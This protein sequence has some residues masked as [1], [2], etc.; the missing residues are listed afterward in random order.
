MDRAGLDTLDPVATRFTRA[1]AWGNRRRWLAIGLPWCALCAGLLFTVLLTVYVSIRMTEVD[2]A[3]FLHEVE[4]IEAR[5]ERRM[6]AHESLL[7]GAAGLLRA[8]DHVSREDWKRYTDQLELQRNYPGLQGLGLSLRIPSS[9]RRAHEST[10]REE[11]PPYAIRP[12]TARDEYHS[13]VYLEPMDA[14]NLRAIGYDMYSEPTRAEAMARA[15]DNGVAALSGQVVLVQEDGR[16]VQPGFLLYYPVYRRD[17]VPDSAGSRREALIG[18]TYSP[19]RAHDLFGNTLQAYSRELGIELFDGDTP[20]PVR[21]LF[22]AGP[23]P[24]GEAAFTDQRVLRLA[25]HQWTLLTRAP[26]GFASARPLLWLLPLGGALL[27]GLL[28]HLLRLLTR[29]QEARLQAQISSHERARS[30][31]RLSA[32]LDHAPDGIVTTDE[33]GRLLT[34]NQSAVNMFGRD[35]SRLIGLPLS[36]LIPDLDAECFL[37]W[38]SEGAGAA[39]WQFRAEMSAVR[40]ARQHFPVIVLASRF[41][42]DGRMNY[43]LLLHDMSEQQAAQMRMRL[44][45]RALESSGEGVVIRDVRDPAYPVVYVNPALERMMKLRGEDLIGRPFTFSR[46]ADERH[47]VYDDL[48]RAIAQDRT[49]STTVEVSLPSGEVLWLALSSSPVRDVTGRVTHYIDIIGDVSER[50]RFERTLIRRTHRLNAVFSLSP[51]GFVTIDAGGVISN[52]NPAFLQ[53]TGL[54]APALQG[55]TLDGLDRAMSALADPSRRWPPVAQDA[56]RDSADHLWMRI[57]EPRVLERRVR[58][59]REG[60]SETVLYFRDVTQQIELDRVKSEFLGTAAHELRSPLASIS[61]FAELLLNREYDETARKRMY[62][63]IHRQSRLLVNLVNDLLDLGRIEARAGKDFRYEEV[64][65][66][67]LVSAALES[68]GAIDDT[69]PVAL[70][71]PDSEPCV[72]ADRDKMVRVLINVL[73][74][75]FKYSP[76]GSEVCIAVGEGTRAG[77]AMAGISVRDHGIGM[78]E[79]QKARMCERFYRADPTGPVPGTGLGMALVKEIV[80]LHDGDIDVDSAPGEGTTVTLWLPSR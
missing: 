9:D 54:S 22:R 69:H 30:E 68:L 76:P 29:S 60:R 10:V 67:W 24:E 32:V 39:R 56:A 27:S 15:R 80:A 12:D 35:P 62:G 23:A 7:R 71:L 36:R 1:H 66:K 45:D 37:R 21:R 64:P 72:R 74:N 4:R 48:R 5:I 55:L 58:M 8:S 40:N 28:F 49:L 17:S 33:S 31:K 50:V 53:M 65:L 26:S 63:I 78:T 73:T 6:I 13:I 34:L 19:F 14:R 75:A 61:G 25:G 46:D 59:V 16:D 57:P 79:E 77:R 47:P 3:R 52:V 42:M 2:R 44:H 18:F 70:D 43:T 41:E 51:D 20:S 11:Y 38:R